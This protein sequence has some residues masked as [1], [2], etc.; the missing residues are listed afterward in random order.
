MFPGAD[1]VRIATA[2]VDVVL[3][4]LTING[5]GGNN[6]IYMSAGRSLTVE[7]CVIGNLSQNGIY[8]DAAAIVN[9]TDTTARRNAFNEILLSSGSR[10]V[11]TRAA[12]SNNINHGIYVVGVAPNTF[13]Y[14]DIGDTTADGNSNG[15][16]ASSSNATASV[17]VSIRDSRAARNQIGIYAFSDAGAKVLLTASNNIISNNSL[18]GV[19][20][21]YVGTKVWI[22]GN[23]TSANTGRLVVASS[24]LFETAGNNAMRNNTVDVTDPIT[25]IASK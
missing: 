9:I 25:A 20:A 2:D 10:A 16:Y 22:S 3:R 8:V 12:V 15:F 14:A 17:S 13:T 5:Q 24:A 19:A 7:N 18:Y 23:T 4:G 11:I 21:E 6:G 1:G